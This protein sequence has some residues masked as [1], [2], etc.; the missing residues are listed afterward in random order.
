MTISKTTTH[1][2]GEAVPR[3]AADLLADAHAGMQL[4]RLCEYKDCRRRRRCYCKAAD[5]CGMYLAPKAWAWVREAVTALREGASPRLAAW[6]ADHAVP[7]K[8][9]TIVGTEYS[10]RPIVLA[11]EDD[12]VMVPLEGPLRPTP[13]ARQLRRLVGPRGAW[14]RGE[15]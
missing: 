5:S 6:A 8:R 1:A 10:G 14:L 4:W 3:W 13:W 2:D 12:G 9:R 7:R 11:A 15:L